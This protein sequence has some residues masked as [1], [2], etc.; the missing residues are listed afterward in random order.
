M[1]F[2]PL[3]VDT[4]IARWQGMTGKKARRSSGETF[5]DLAKERTAK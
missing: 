2:D 4:A 5:N 1:E 3:Y